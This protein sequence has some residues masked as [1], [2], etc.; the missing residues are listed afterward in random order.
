[1]NL[2]VAILVNFD[3]YE[4]PQLKEVKLPNVAEM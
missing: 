4:V 1:M 2:I 3:D